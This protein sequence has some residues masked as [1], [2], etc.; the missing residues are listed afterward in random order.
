MTD[1][2]SRNVHRDVSV[3]FHRYT[4]TPACIHPLASKILLEVAKQTRYV[5]RLTRSNGYD[6]YSCSD[7]N[8]LRWPKECPCT[9]PPCRL[10][11][12]VHRTRL[13]RL[14]SYGSGTYEA[15]RTIY[16]PSSSKLRYH[17]A[18]RRAL[19]ST[20]ALRHSDI[21]S[22]NTTMCNACIENACNLRLT[23][24]VRRIARP[25]ALL[26]A[27]DRLA[28]HAGVQARAR[29]PTRDW[30]AWGLRH[31]D[32]EVLGTAETRG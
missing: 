32:D 15:Q 12:N 22:R 21:K 23:N 14:N 25:P 30:W 5:A 13:A 20:F 8:L 31:S 7:P 17:R 29:A 28:R 3:H 26:P 4:P 6:S 9:V 16:V 10:C 24:L 19:A 1:H 11:F 27:P 2:G 18:P